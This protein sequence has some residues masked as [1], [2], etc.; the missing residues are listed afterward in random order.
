MRELV[1]A[2]PSAGGEG[3]GLWTNYAKIVRGKLKDWARRRTEFKSGVEKVER[4]AFLA[5]NMPTT[6]F[7]KLEVVGGKE[8]DLEKK[9]PGRKKLG[10]NKKFCPS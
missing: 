10:R 5:Q 9:Q 1:L 8:T 3:H 4:W 7:S 2:G 6:F